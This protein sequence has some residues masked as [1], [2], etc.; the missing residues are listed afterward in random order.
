MLLIYDF[1]LIWVDTVHFRYSGKR[2][3]ILSYLFII[4]LLLFFVLQL[5][6]VCLLGAQKRRVLFGTHDICFD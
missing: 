2:E 5:K 6:Q 3:L 1:E 4:K